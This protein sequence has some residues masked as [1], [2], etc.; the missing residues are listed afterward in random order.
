MAKKNQQVETR[1]I[2]EYVKERYSQ[3]PFTLKQPLGSI[4]ED[5][6]RDMGF[7]KA[8]RLSRPT[9]PE[10]DAVVFR[11]KQLILIEAKVWHIIDGLAKLPLYRSLIPVTPELA[12]VKD[13]EILME[14]VVPWTNPNLETMAASVGAKVVLYK[15]LWIDEVV[16]NVQRYTTRE[17]RE[18]REEK[19]RM[20]ELLGLD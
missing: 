5:L 6:A 19:N 4:N 2:A 13:Q 11:P 1:L 20:R 3:F 18:A 12:H 10:A 17:Y 8:L 16:E 14:I 7:E 15:P 9:R